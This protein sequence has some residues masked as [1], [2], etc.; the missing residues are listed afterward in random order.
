MNK[1]TKQ[2]LKKNNNIEE[3]II[4]EN[5][6]IWTNMTLY[7]RGSN[8]TEYNQELVREDIIN[9]ILDG[10]QRGDNIQKVMGGRYKEICDEIIDAMPKKTKKD[11]IVEVVGI[12]LD[13]LWISGVIS[14]VYN[15]IRSLI[16]KT[17]DFRYILSVGDIILLLTVILVTEGIVWFA[18]KIALNEKKEKK[19]RSFL[20]MWLIATTIMAILILSKYYLEI[21]VVSIPLSVAAVIVLFIYIVAK[22]ADKI[23]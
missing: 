23:T 7:L 10:Q 12:F 1:K 9:L 6:E 4:D 3:S 8:L 19:I 16:S 14:I 17:T 15:I 11:W 5:Q 13:P 18:T 2:L 21:I 20:T 22:I